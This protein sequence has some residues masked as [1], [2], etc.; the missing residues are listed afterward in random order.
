LQHEQAQYEASL[1]DEMR[2]YIEATGLEPVRVRELAA[3]ARERKQSVLKLLVDRAGCDESVVLQ[4]LA[5]RLGLTFLADESVAIATE[6]LAAVPAP[7]ALQHQVVPLSA[8]NGTMRMASSD[9]FNWHDWDELAHLIGQPIEKVLCP[10]KVVA[11]LLK[12][13]YGL[14]ADTVDR[15]L[16]EKKA[17]TVQVSSTRT[18]NLSEEEAASEPTVVNLVN[19]ILTEAIRADATDIHCEPYESRYRIRYRIDGVLED[20]SMPVSVNMLKLALVSRIKIMANLDITEKRMPQDGRCQV[21]LAGH[22]FDLRVSILPSMYGE[23]VNIRLQRRHMVKMDLE[24]LGFQSHEYKRIHQLVSRPHGLLLVTG[25]T[26]SGKTTT[27]YTC[28]ARINKPDTKI[29]TIEDPVEYW[30]EDVLQM[31]VHEAIGFTFA[32]ALRGI[33][34]H[35]PD[36]MLVGEIRDRETADIAIRSSLTGHLVFA[37]LHT[38]D[39][40]SA[41]TR[42][43]DIGIEPFLLASSIQGVV[44]QR[45]V[46]KICQHCREQVPRCSL[47]DYEQEILRSAGFDDAVVLWR[48]R[49]CDR[50]R[51]SGFRGRTAVAEVL[52][53]SPALRRLIQERSPA[54]QIQQVACQER[55][56]TLW[57]SALQA[58]RSGYTTIGE[59]IRVA[60]EGLVM[61][62]DDAKVGL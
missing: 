34:R 15:L 56:Q 7:V 61:G 10:S 5:E 57:T 48:G 36:I 20:V 28:L 11:R 13:N 52:V 21:T 45:L 33:L 51:F 1:P 37:T 59:A 30:M 35:D 9:P 41:V 12:I 3:F 53:V 54:E 49:G 58:V 2:L 19:Q 39:A 24:S 25:P 38:N 31:Q 42:L 23:A 26:G 60:Q 18:T 4:R 16:S 32:R 40:A 46:R 8:A 6:L 50:C 22:A 44:A 14:G 43:L 47:E 17:D 27:L 55:M 62:T 29:I